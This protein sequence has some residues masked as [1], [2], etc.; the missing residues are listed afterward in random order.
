M[1]KILTPKSNPSQTVA[2]RAK[3]R[4]LILEHHG[5]IAALKAVRVE[6]HEAWEL[7]GGR[8][9]LRAELELKDGSY[10]TFIRVVPFALPPAM[11]STY[12]D[13]T[14]VTK[15][16]WY[17]YRYQLLDET[18]AAAGESEGDLIEAKYVEQ[19]A[20]RA[21]DRLI[22]ERVK[23]KPVAKPLRQAPAAQKI[24]AE[25]LPAPT[26]SPV[27]DSPVPSPAGSEQLI[28]VEKEPATLI[29]RARNSAAG[30]LPVPAIIAR[31]D[32]KTAKRFLEFFTVTIRNPNTRAAYARACGYFLDW[33]H[34]RGLTLHTI[35]PMH[36]AAYIEKL[37][38]EREAQ[39]VKQH[40]AGIRMLFDWLVIGQSV[41]FNPAAS[42][43]GPSYSYKKG[44]TPILD[45][46]GMKQLLDGIDTSTIVGLRD[47]ALIA[48]MFYTFGRVSAAI[49]MDVKDYYPR[50]KRYFIGL[51]EKGG[52]YHEVPVHHKAE[53]CSG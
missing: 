5:D 4:R 37:T 47:R 27:A 24:E 17:G 43:K 34:R 13:W 14:I 16:T 36:V 12:R 33:C 38:K 15:P 30:G 20:R 28:V 22:A 8:V 53:E 29:E 32:Q 3:L 46:A 52:K 42:V 1:K 19:N 41:S 31:E 35:E 11:K 45:E 51:R 50:S 23:T 18:G 26:A 2:L 7:S 21:I 25:L 40:L 10:R 48:L 39:T 44:K 49:A 9:K 6:V